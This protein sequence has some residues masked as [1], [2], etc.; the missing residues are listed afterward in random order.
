L[1]N[2]QREAAEAR[3]RLARVEDD[4]LAPNRNPPP[5]ADPLLDAAALAPLPAATA[6]E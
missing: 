2:R 4:A 1:W 3:E 6:A 5:V